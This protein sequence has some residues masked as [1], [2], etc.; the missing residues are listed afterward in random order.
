MRKH[1][2]TKRSTTVGAV[3]ELVGE[4]H[5]KPQKWAEIATDGGR[6]APCAGRDTPTRPKPRSVSLYEKS[7]SLK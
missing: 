5:V 1:T 3:D 2:P 4:L 6:T 7:V